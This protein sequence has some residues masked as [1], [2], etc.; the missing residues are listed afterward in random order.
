MVESVSAFESACAF[1]S[2]FAFESAYAF[3]SVFA[4]DSTC[5]RDR[6]LDL[7]G[8]LYVEDDEFRKPIE[9]YIRGLET[10]L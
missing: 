7:E 6:I 8:R 1:E 2:V 9:G 3:E 4:F 10:D 5:F